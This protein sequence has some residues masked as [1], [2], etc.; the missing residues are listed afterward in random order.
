ME[1]RRRPGRELVGL[2]SSYATI[3]HRLPKPL[4]VAG[5]RAR[6]AGAARGTSESVAVAVII[7]RGPAGRASS[8]DR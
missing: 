5:T 2:S 7:S 3:L 1:R 6:G 4:G 8:S